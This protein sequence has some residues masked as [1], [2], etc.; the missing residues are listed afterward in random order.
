M[1]LCFLFNNNVQR[2]R[3]KCTTILSK[4]LLCEK[5]VN[6]KVHVHYR[7]NQN[8]EVPEEME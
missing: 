7:L 3:L 1:F 8:T 4:L 2:L 5:I 6:C